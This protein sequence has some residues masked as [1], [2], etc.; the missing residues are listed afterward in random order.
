V[1]STESKSLTDWFERVYVINRPDRPERLERFYKHIEKN[2]VADPN[3]IVVYPAV[4][5]DKTSF[6]SYFLSGAGA[7]GCLRSHSN[8]VEGLI[9][10]QIVTGIKVPNI[11]ILED[12]VE[13]I[14]NCLEMIGAFLV[15]V[16]PDWDQIYLGGQ[17]RLPHEKTS[18]SRIFRGNS[19][20]RTHAYA[21]KRKV[22][23]KFY[24][25]I[26]HAPDYMDKK[27]HHVDH[28]LE[29]AHR[30]KDWNVYCPPIWYAGQAE[31]K[32]DVCEQDLDSRLWQ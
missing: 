30:R 24:V 14:P 16:P 17:H 25:H 20:N 18:V 29:L 8:I 3:K 27:N 12:D 6:P 11:L 15:K 26:N 13:F 22:Y 5:G 4:M 7:W 10:E 2:G 1:V 19:I 28:Q 23:K 9:N 32:S 21:L 31:G